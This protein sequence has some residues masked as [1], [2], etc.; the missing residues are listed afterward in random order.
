[1]ADG[2]TYVEGEK[3]R[4]EAIL[5]TF[6]EEGLYLIGILGIIQIIDTILKWF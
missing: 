4:N 2:Q 3:M 1:M 5:L 6:T